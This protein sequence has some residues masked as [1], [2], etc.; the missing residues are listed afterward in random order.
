[1]NVRKS[2]LS[3]PAGIS[4]A[5]IFGIALLFRVGFPYDQIF[6]SDWIKFA[7]VDAYY[8]MR[9]VDNL[10]HNFP[11]LNSFDPYS[12]YPGGDMVGGFRFFN[13]LL[14]G[15]IWVIGL[16]SP[17][18]HTVDTIGAYFPAVLGA[19]T[20]IPVYFI[21]KELFGRWAGVI[22]AGLIALIPGEFIGRS[23]LGFT[24]HDVANTLFT[25]LAILF[26]ILAIKTAGQRQ[27]T[28]G[29]L[30][31]RDWKITIKPAVYSLLVGV[32]LG[33]YML[34]W[35]GALFFVFVISAYLI[36]QFIIDHLRHKSTDYLCLIGVILFFVTMVIFAPFSP[37]SLYISVL[38]IA[39][40][41]PLI[42]SGLSR[43]MSYKEIKP[44]YYP[45]ALVGLAL[46]GLAIFYAIAPSLL[47]T[48][49]GL[50]SIFSWEGANLT[51]LE[52]QPLLFPQGKW[53]IALGWGN[54]TTGFFF[55][56]GAL[57]Y[58]IFYRGLIRRQG[59]AE[60]NLLLVWSLVILAATLGQ[61]RFASYLAVNVALLTGYLSWQAIWFAGFRQARTIGVW[62]GMLLLLAT[63]LYSTYLYIFLPVWL[64]AFA[65]L[66]YGCRAWAK[67]K[68]RS[69]LWALLGLLPPIGFIPLALMQAETAKIKSK[70]MHEESQNVSIYYINS[71]L[72]IIVVLILA[73]FPNIKASI[74]V[75]ERA[76]FAPSDAW[77]VSLSWMKDNTPDPF[78]NPDFYY[79]RYESPP[80]G[81]SYNYPESAYGV[82][83]WWDYG[84]WITR[85][86]HRLPNANPGQSP[87]PIINIANLFLSQ[88]EPPTREM[89]QKLESSYIILDYSTTTSKFWAIVNWAGREQNEFFEVYY[90][91]Y[92]NRLEPVQLYYPEYY[93]SICT[94]LYNFDGQ[95]VTPTNPIVISYV[96]KTNLEGKP[97]KQITT[98]QDFPGYEEALSYI[99]SQKS[100]NVRIVS[101]NPFISPVPLEALSNYKLVYSSDAGV[102]HQDAGM[103]PEVKIFEYTDAVE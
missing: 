46:A 10:V 19:L 61:R 101:G 77:Q 76:R 27:I 69:E 47:K 2:L 33:I 16:G 23:I 57:L 89:M 14:A 35:A 39:S 87:E 22:S 55:F 95:A 72:A 5:I 60:E 79:E 82:T 52:M 93:R 12:I 84:Y 73:F 15:I 20:V 71:A 25:T 58:L 88:E 85:I 68:G 13:W 3:L 36:V 65:S 42:L 34:T 28:F 64:T 56:L 51:T 53:T 103:V 45:L 63:P 9:L 48:M 98:A 4:V 90:L 50:F 70:G 18:Q 17:T 91:P 92:E 6:G 97:Y 78:N 80:K 74:A 40:L 83:A 102:L 32:F 44:A 81:E 38:I 62:T 75:A 37:N 99:E 26:M 96:E 94:R 43:L 30:N 49:L 7:S 59:S 86:A 29:F 41:I 24:D 11:H 67:Y 100:A 54:F 21:G 8:Q 31:R 1:M 66:L